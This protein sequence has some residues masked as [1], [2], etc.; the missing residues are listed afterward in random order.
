M[1]ETSRL[2]GR[3]DGSERPENEGD[4]SPDHGPDRRDIAPIE[5]PDAAGPKPQDNVGKL[6]IALDDA[7]PP[8]EPLVG[9]SGEVAE[10]R[11][12]DKPQVSL[13]ALEATWEAKKNRKKS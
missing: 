2:Q 11:D 9:Y 6:T 10:W 8:S 12:L 5:A 3:G 4:L 7:A 1:E 13:K